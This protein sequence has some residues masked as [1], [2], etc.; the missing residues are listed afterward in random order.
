MLGPEVANE[1]Q[2]DR[3]SL[4]NLIISEVYKVL[5][6]YVWWGSVRVLVECK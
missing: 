2:L 5:H 4:V 6:I 1:V 3:A